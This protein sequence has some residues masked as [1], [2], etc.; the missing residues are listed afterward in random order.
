MDEPPLEER[1]GRSLR[2]AYWG[3]WLCLP[4]EG[5]E[6]EVRGQACET[7][8]EDE[9]TSVAKNPQGILGEKGATANTRLPWTYSVRGTEYLRFS[10]RNQADR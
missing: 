8:L 3:Y 1:F 10:P 6:Q 7:L 2:W 4:R 5:T 9:A